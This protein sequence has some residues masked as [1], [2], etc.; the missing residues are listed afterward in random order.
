VGFYRELTRTASALAG[1]AAAGAISDLPAVAGPSGASRTIFL[2]SDADFQ[3]VVLKRPVAMIRSVTSGYFAASGSVL[4]A[5]RFLSEQEDAPAAVVSESLARGLWP[6]EPAA[7]VVGRTLRQGN[8]QGPLITVVGV[9]ADVR[10]GAVDRDLPPYI[11]RPHGQWAGGSMTL[12][13]RT[14]QEPAEVAA[15][16]RAAIRSIDPNLPIPTIRTMREILSA[17]VAQRRFQMLLT[18]LFA[19]V[20]LLLGAV[21]VYGVVSYAVACRTREVGLRMA[22]GAMKGDVLRWVLAQGMKP[23]AIGLIAGLGG[24][25]AIAR[26]LR[27]LLFEIPPADPV[28]LG[29][30]TA[31]LLLTS[32]LACYVPARRAARLDPMTA[33]RHE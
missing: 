15:P 10:P 29:G 31:I 4:Q 24:A 1:V 27:G 8:V 11:Y 20:A 32:G 12:L 13:A 21:G 22:L 33:L 9:V 28:S 30:V 18:S 16:L 7:A 25:I 5:G 6:G 17:S 23:V 2:D 26:T 3:S 14:A 19:V